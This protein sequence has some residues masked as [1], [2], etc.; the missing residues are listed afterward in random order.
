MKVN[1]KSIGK[2]RWDEMYRR[3]K[4]WFE[5]GEL[6]KGV[7]EVAVRSFK[8]KL[9][10]FEM[11]EG[12][13]YL[14][15]D[16]PPDEMMDIPMKLPYRLEVVEPSKENIDAIISE[17]FVNIR[18]GSF[19]GVNAIYNKLKTMYVG[20]KRND[21]ADVLKRMELKQLQRTAE[22][23]ELIT[24]EPKRV[25]E[26]VQVDLVEIREHVRINEDVNYLLNVIDHFSKFAWSIPIKNK[27]SAVVADRL[28]ELF[29]VEGFPEVLQSDNGTEFV[30]K[31]MTSLSERYGFELKHSLPYHS[32]AQGLV[33]R[34]NRTIQ[35]A[36]Y[37]YTLDRGVKKW[38][39]NLCFFVYAY[40]TTVHSTTELTPFQVFR[41]KNEVFKLDEVV[42]KRI[43][44]NAEMMRKKAM[45]G[46]I[47]D[48]LDDLKVGD[49]VRILTSATTEVRRM[50][51][52]E[53]YSKRKKKKLLNYTK[54]IY[55]IEKVLE[56]TYE[57][58]EKRYI[59]SYRETGIK[60][61]RSF[62]RE[63]LMKIEEDNIEM[64]GKERVEEDKEMRFGVKFNLEDH[65]I[66][67]NTGVRKEADLTQTQLDE[68][69]EKAD[70]RTKRGSRKRVDYAKLAGGKGVQ[71]K[72]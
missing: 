25:M 70:T 36:I 19:R 39:D 67:M 11:V 31:E 21:V 66:T 49:R 16:N 59:T 6:P 35:E 15:A 38:V 34:F 18:V 55:E 4:D 24:I 44:K 30:N 41:K 1:W 52:I 62:F 45:K 54:E 61:V 57:I 68:R 46:K 7:S 33:E 23:R 69:I 37:N 14:V 43:K 13:I 65:L 40:N 27:S 47:R 17:V 53:R 22:I 2:Y 48:V 64:S 26:I 71:E 42:R 8:R 60:L 28:Q 32:Q 5:K 9:K 20:I 10:Q 12:R 56:P 29:L 50:T 58:K 63:D 51:D 72:K 3:L